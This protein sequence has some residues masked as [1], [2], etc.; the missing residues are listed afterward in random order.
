MG[1]VTGQKFEVAHS[2]AEDYDVVATWL[3]DGTQS[4]AP[5]QLKEVPP[6]APPG[7]PPVES[8]MIEGGRPKVAVVQ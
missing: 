1:E 2:E 7:N 5:I 8:C 6:T 4:F 3:K